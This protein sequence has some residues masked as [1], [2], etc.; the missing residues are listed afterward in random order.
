MDQSQTHNQIKCTCTSTASRNLKHLVCQVLLIRDTQQALQS[1]I[2]YM[3]PSAE[4]AYLACVNNTPAKTHE[5]T[6]HLFTIKRSAANFCILPA[7]HTCV[8]V[9]RVYDYINQNMEITQYSVYD[10]FSLS[11]DL[12]PTPPSRPMPPCSCKPFRKWKWCAAGGWLVSFVFRTNMHSSVGG[13]FVFE[14][15]PAQV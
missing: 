14:S 7:L 8:F 1:A 12:L 13:G 2:N 3:L 10:I 6:K 15:S 4:F 5:T 9:C 11:L